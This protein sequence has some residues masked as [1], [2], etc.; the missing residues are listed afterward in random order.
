MKNQIWVRRAATTE[1]AQVV[2]IIQEGLGARVNERTIYGSSGIKRY[3]EDAISAVDFSV[4]QF[5]AAGVGQQVLAVAQASI[6]Q[7]NVMLSYICTRE[8]SRSMGLGRELMKEVAQLG[9][10]M[11]GSVIL[12]VFRSNIRAIH[13]YQSFN[14]VETSKLGWWELISERRSGG[15]NGPVVVSGLPQADVCHTQFGFSEFT[16][17]VDS[18]SYHVGRL[19]S[20][21]FRLTDV[22]AACDPDLVAALN[23]LEPGRALLVQ[24]LIDDRT[25]KFL[26]DPVLESIHMSVEI[27]L[28][29][30]KLESNS[31]L[32]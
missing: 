4:P 12:D 11:D 3:V 21:W 17:E 32:L 18:G 1:A 25:A 28:L 26:G 20:K 19:G 23:K 24:C 16:L 29:R 9:S 2:E 22:A 7:R 31:G 13:W 10:E 15:P 14:F 27:G 8:G 5:F 6:R 30:S